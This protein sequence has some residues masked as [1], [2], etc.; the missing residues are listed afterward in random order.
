MSIVPQMSSLPP[1][2][3]QCGLDFNQSKMPDLGPEFEGNSPLEV[4]R[5]PLSN[6]LGRIHKKYKDLD[7]TYIEN[8]VNRSLQEQNSALNSVQ[9]KKNENFISFVRDNTYLRDTIFHRLFKYKTPLGEVLQELQDSQE[10]VRKLLP[11]KTFIEAEK[12]AEELTSLVSFFEQDSDFCVMAGLSVSTLNDCG[13]SPLYKAIEKGQIEIARLLLKLGASPIQKNE[14]DNYFKTDPY[15]RGKIDLQQYDA[16]PMRAAMKS[17]EINFVKLLCENGATFDDEPGYDFGRTP[18]FGAVHA[19]HEE[20][21]LFLIENGARA[22]VRDNGGISL[23]AMAVRV[24][25]PRVVQKLVEKGVNVVG[26][27]D[28][29]GL[30]VL[31]VS[32]TGGAIRPSRSPEILKILLE[33]GANEGI[34]T[35]DRGETLLE[36]AVSSNVL[37]NVKLLVKHGADLKSEGREGV[38]EFAKKNNKQA[39]VEF[40]CE[41]DEYSHLKCKKDEEDKDIGYKQTIVNFFRKFFG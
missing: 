16:K 3:M 32:V 11:K 2:A 19:G 14:G 10:T 35:L 26:D 17:G 5:Y 12:E 23:I 22:D 18:V 40:L 41:L 4:A 25:L 37:E 31:R 24:G 21:A 9:K 39:I 30:S 1:V 20:L 38:L 27:Q 13:I 7:T 33:N 8:V 6:Y 34:N 36:I 29:H 15:F 28:D